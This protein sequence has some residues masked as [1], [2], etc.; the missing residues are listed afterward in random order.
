M[1]INEFC[2]YGRGSFGSFFFISILWH[3][4]VSPIQK[5]IINLTS[6]YSRFSVHSFHS[7]RFNER[8]MPQNGTILFVLYFLKSN[9]NNWAY[10]HV[11]E[12]IRQKSEKQS[13]LVMVMQATHPSYVRI[14]QT[15]FNNR[16]I[17]CFR[18][19]RIFMLSS[20][21]NMTRKWDI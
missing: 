1:Q 10:W 5:I 12:S 2:S 6:S 16:K 17:A 18:G 3:A 8:K 4:I 20:T 14:L 7:I 19:I 21:T 15:K 13:Q 11:N 9:S